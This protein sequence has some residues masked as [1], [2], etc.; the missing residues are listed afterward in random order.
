[1]G[2]NAP[3]ALHGK[4]FGERSE[5]FSAAARR[6]SNGI[7]HAAEPLRFRGTFFVFAGPAGTGGEG[8]SFAPNKRYSGRFRC[9]GFW[10]FDMIRSIQ[11]G[12]ETGGGKDDENCRMRK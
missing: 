3:N 9:R 7:F 11:S 1:M 5:D 6:E 10:E 2:S 8:L 12:E 4:A